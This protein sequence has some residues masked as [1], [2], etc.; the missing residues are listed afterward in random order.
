MSKLYSLIILSLLGIF[1]ILFYSPNKRIKGNE[2]N[3]NIPKTSIKI[4]S[5]AYKE[6]E[7]LSIE[8]DYIFSISFKTNKKVE[9]NNT[10]TIASNL[11]KT[12]N[13][14]SGFMIEIKKTAQGLIPF[15]YWNNDLNQGG[16]FRFNSLGVN[17]N[18]SWATLFLTYTNKTLGLYSISINSKNQTKINNLGAHILKNDV[19]PNNEN[20]LKV[21]SLRSKFFSGKI[22][23]LISCNSYTI[24]ETKQ[25]TLLK[26]ILINNKN[27]SY[28]F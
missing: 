8:K 28:L 25:I 21:G 18:N 26:D 17:L 20:N 14:Q 19:L 2:I 24:E 16:W 1:F 23:N 7:N 12:G 13:K 6:V 9:R 15:I 22:A 4:K 3:L 5:A 10:I 27:C 11:V